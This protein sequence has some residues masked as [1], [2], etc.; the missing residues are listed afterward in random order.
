MLVIREGQVIEQGPTAQL[1]QSAT[2]DYTREL[3]AAT[4]RLRKGASDGHNIDL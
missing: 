3:L 1:L 4:P 2:E